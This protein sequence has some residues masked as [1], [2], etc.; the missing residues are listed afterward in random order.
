[1][2]SVV[3]EWPSPSSAWDDPMPSLDTAIVVPSMIFMI[4]VLRLP[5]MSVPVPIGTLTA[6]TKGGR[7]QA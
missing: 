4:F 7:A 6:I 2:N 1:V 3:A 5:A